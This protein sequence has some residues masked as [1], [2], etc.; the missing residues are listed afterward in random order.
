MWTLLPAKK[1]H[2]IKVK[3]GVTYRGTRGNA[4]DCEFTVKRTGAS[5]SVEFTRNGKIVHREIIYCHPGQMTLSYLRRRVNM[6]L[7]GVAIYEWVAKCPNGVTATP[8]QEPVKMPSQKFIIWCPT[9]EMPP[10]VILETEETA[11]EVALD[12]ARRHKAEFYW[13][14]LEGKVTSKKQVTYTEVVTV[15]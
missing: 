10:R 1:N 8:E 12:M 2:T 4:V 13:A 9:S 14:R 15:L 7:N 11:Q 6:W 3:E 5:C